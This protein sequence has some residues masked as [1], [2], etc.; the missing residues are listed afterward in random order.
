M[1]LARTTN[2]GPG[3]PDSAR[4][5]E[6]QPL[7]AAARVPHSVRRSAAS[8]GSGSADHASGNRL[9]PGPTAEDSSPRAADAR[10]A[11]S[12]VQPAV[13][14]VARLYAAGWQPETIAAMRGCNI[15]SVYTMASRA[16]AAGFNLRNMSVG[17]HRKHDYGQILALARRGKRP[18][19]I[20][21]EL[22]IPFNTVVHIIIDMRDAGAI[23]AYPKAYRSPA[24][25]WTDDLFARALE[26][27]VE[28]GA[29]AAAREIGATHSAVNREIQR[30][31]YSVRK[32]RAE[33]KATR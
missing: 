9:L 29:K 31:G 30:R 20:A 6:R 17:V 15:R 8:N 21:R 33:R 14:E 25:R 1:S 10:G 4:S 2:A 7:N 16:R 19:E 11:F 12:R 13:R 18:A 5:N 32:I 23:V 3:N 24:V 27:A 28:H 26:L 22:S